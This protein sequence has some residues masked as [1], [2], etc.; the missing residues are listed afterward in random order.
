MAGVTVIV[1]SNARGVALTI[2]KIGDALS[3]PQELFLQLGT[4][5]V[6]DITKRITT[7]DDGHW[8]SPSK[9][10]RAKKNTDRALAGIEKYLHSKAT[11]SNLQVYAQTDGEWSFTQHDQ[12]FENI[13]NNQQ[14]DRIVID[15]VN[16]GPLGLPAAGE[17]S[18][19]PHNGSGRT[20][21][22]KIWPTAEDARAIANPIF[23][24]WVE[25]QINKLG[26]AAPQEAL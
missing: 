6:D 23:S 10:V 11:N 25:A 18:W 2:N 8:A 26:A 1:K 24:R 4:A 13:E 20:P 16:P 7:Q 15:V 12:G 9:W 19:I 3:H 21:A 22:R 14:G 17:F 5:F